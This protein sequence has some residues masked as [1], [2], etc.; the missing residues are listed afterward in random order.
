[1]SDAM[2]TSNSNVTLRM[3]IPGREIGV[4]IGKGGETI[5]QI[6]AE[7]EAKIFIS[8]GSVPE[9]VITVTGNQTQRVLLYTKFLYFLD[10]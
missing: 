8:D 6:R 3:I 7:S 4:L 10:F 9:R 2:D 5:H 1:M